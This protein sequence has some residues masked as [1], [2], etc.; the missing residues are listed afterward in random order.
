MCLN[1]WVGIK[2]CFQC[3]NIQDMQD[4]D[5]KCYD[6]VVYIDVDASMM[7]LLDNVLV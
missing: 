6:D 2:L 1:F 7:D 4:K 3:N 5:A